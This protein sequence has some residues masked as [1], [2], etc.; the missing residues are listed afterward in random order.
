MNPS[1]KTFNYCVTEIKWPV[2]LERLPD[3]GSCLSIR[4]TRPSSA[5]SYQISIRFKRSRTWCL[6]QHCLYTSHFL[7]SCLSRK[8]FFHLK[9]WVCVCTYVCIDECAGHVFFSWAVSQCCSGS[10]SLHSLLKSICLPILH[11]VLLSFRKA[12][13][14]DLFTLPGSFCAIVPAFLYSFNSTSRKLQN[15][16]GQWLQPWNL[17]TLTCSLEEKLWQT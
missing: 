1:M 13:L 8:I 15:H 3:Q 5:T 14:T 12:L 11:A 17:K 7:W 16:W 4:S 10:A 9:W 6:T 2:Q